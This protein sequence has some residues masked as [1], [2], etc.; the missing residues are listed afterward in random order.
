MIGSWQ[1]IKAFPN[2]SK[3]AQMHYESNIVQA[4]DR[5]AQ[6]GLGSGVAPRNPTIGAAGSGKANAATISIAVYGVYLLAN[7]VGLAA[8]PSVLLMLLALPAP[9]EPWIRVLGLVAAELGF[10]FLY[11][12]RKGITSFYPA[13]VIGRVVTAC[14]F[15]ALAALKAGPMQLLIFAAVDLLSA[16]WT[17]LAIKRSRAA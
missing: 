11:A 3:E 9:G 10:Y 16:I 12:A 15:V 8:T 14:V 5:P 6:V 2:A 7:G 4:H 17:Q 1:P 13:T